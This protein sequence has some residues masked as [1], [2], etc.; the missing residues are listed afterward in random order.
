M[1]Q[2]SPLLMQNWYMWQKRPQMGGAA[3][4]YW[5]IKFCHTF[6][7]DA[8]RTSIGVQDCLVSFPA[9][10]GGGLW[11]HLYFQL[12]TAK[13]SAHFESVLVKSS[14]L[15]S[16]VFTEIRLSRR[17]DDISTRGYDSWPPVRGDGPFNPER[18]PLQTLMWTD[19]LPRLSHHNMER[20]SSHLYPGCQPPPLLNNHHDWLDF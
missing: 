16:C 17:G 18:H 2:K 7:G 19:W 11:V 20:V 10:G 13:F 1:F 4:W 8:E 6:C 3:S 15:S 5:L 14:A 9:W 12:I